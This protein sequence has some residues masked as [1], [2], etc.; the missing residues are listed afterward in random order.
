MELFVAFLLITICLFIFLFPTVAFYA[1]SLLVLL[2]S[3]LFIWLYLNY[4]H[5]IMPID[6]LLNLIILSA[7]LITF[8]FLLFQITAVALGLLIIK[9]LKNQQNHAFLLTKSAVG[10]FGKRLITYRKIFLFFFL[11]YR[12]KI[13]YFVAHQWP[14]FIAILTLLVTITFLNNLKTIHMK[15]M[16]EVAQIKMHSR[17][18]SHNFFVCSESFRKGRATKNSFSI[19]H[20]RR[21]RIRQ[22]NLVMI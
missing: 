7:L 20:Q 4:F 13:F 6:L 3:V 18:A 10:T 5:G 16:P 17:L 21:S 14:L 12:K 19:F 8:P 2:P 1:Y 9:K 22:R 15:N 11:A